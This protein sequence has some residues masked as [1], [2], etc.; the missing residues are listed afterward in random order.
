MWRLRPAV[1]AGATWAMFAV[2]LA[3]R[4]L[5]LHGTRA[6]VPFPSRLPAASARGVNGVLHRLSP[7]C[8][9]RALVAQAWR[10]AHGDLR[11]IVI[12][13]P[14]DGLKRAPAHAWLDGVD[15]AS[16]LVHVEIH[17]MPPRTPTIR[18]H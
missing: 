3:R 2:C 16:P 8:L 14:P 13:V 6:Y 18:R 11:D 1:L 10:A 9:E 12:G 4:R 17:R 7:T 15:T 5:R